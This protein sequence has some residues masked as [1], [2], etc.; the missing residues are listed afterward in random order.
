MMDTILHENEICE[1][2]VDNHTDCAHD[3]PTE[4]KGNAPNEQSNTSENPGIPS[5]ISVGD[6]S[7]E[8]EIGT[9]RTCSL[10]ACSFQCDRMLQ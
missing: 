3:L 5:V 2:S 7:A 4:I 1:D 9:F 10:K 6:T 8:K